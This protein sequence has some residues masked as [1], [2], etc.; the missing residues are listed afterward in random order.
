MARLKAEAAVAKAQT[1]RIVLD[2][3]L[4]RLRFQL[5]TSKNLACFRL[6]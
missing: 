4:E 6:I 3:E 5:D 2:L 1:D